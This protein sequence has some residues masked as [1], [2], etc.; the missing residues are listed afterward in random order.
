VRAGRS[1]GRPDGE[2]LR[3]RCPLLKQNRPAGCSGGSRR[4]GGVGD[5]WRAP[6]RPSATRR[7]RGHQRLGR[8]G[9]TFFARPPSQIAIPSTSSTSARRPGAGVDAGPVGVLL[10]G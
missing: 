1:T 8:P 9:G 7:Q 4:P 3:R 5:A 2:S 10:G 6:G